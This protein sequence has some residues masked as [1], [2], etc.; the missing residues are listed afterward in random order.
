MWSQPRCALR[1]ARGPRLRRRRSPRSMGQKKNRGPKAAIL[2][3]S[4]RTARRGRFRLGRR[5]MESPRRCVGP[6]IF[7]PGTAARSPTTWTSK[8]PATRSA[9]RAVPP[10]R[11]CR[12]S[13]RGR[14][15]GA[16]G[17]RLDR[18]ACASIRLPVLR[19]RAPA[20][21]VSRTRHPPPSRDPA[22]L[23]APSRT[24]TRADCRSRRARAAEATTSGRAPMSEPADGAPKDSRAEDRTPKRPFEGHTS[25]GAAREERWGRFESTI[26]CAGAP[27]RR[28]PPTH[29]RALRRRSDDVTR[30]RAPCAGQTAP[31]EGG[32]GLATQRFRGDPTDTCRSR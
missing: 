10:P 21:T 12:V 13:R 14:P 5:R 19:R 20:F 22:A 8:T 9:A 15:R 27:R 16:R 4:T 2:L 18:R 1:C 23:Q 3:E 28:R 25:R 30:P 17:G 24:L 26:R 11:R 6:E 32:T 31:P 7:D 29:S